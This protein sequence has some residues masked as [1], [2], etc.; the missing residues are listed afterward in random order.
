M[1]G[2]NSVFRG[3]LARGLLATF[4]IGIGHS[5]FLTEGVL[6]QSVLGSSKKDWRFDN[7][8]GA[9]VWIVSNKAV[10]SP[11]LRRDI[12]ILI[13]PKYFKREILTK[14]FADLSRKLSDT[15]GV[16]I[17]AYSDEESLHYS[18]VL[19]KL[20]NLEIDWN[21]LTASDRKS[22]GLHINPPVRKDR[23]FRAHYFVDPSREFFYYTPL[24]K[25]AKS[26]D[27]EW[28]VLREDKDRAESRP[29]EKI[30][31]KIAKI[32]PGEWNPD[33]RDV[34]G[35]TQLLYELRN[36]YFDSARMLIMLGAGANECSPG[37]VCPLMLA[38]RGAPVE[39]ISL[40]ID[41]GAKIDAEDGR[42][43]TA[44]MYAAE[45]GNKEAIE[46]L[47]RHG[48]KVNAKDHLSQT[49]L[50]K[51]S[52][53]RGKTEVAELLL[54]AGAEIDATDDEGYTAL[55]RA[56]MDSNLERVK[57]LL[58]W[59]AKTVI[60]D[61]R[62]YTALDLAGL[63]QSSGVRE[64]KEIIKLLDEAIAKQRASGSGSKR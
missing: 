37:G 9:P 64:A 57:L 43:N 35:W 19:N 1:F 40:L 17:E 50:M 27:V 38:A 63:E 46:I 13:E 8:S 16:T 34:M 54:N 45:G 55:M 12:Y 25:P 56:V 24:A 18:I 61:K 26:N 33:A 39:V 7:S 30:E 47:L 52:D 48:A 22:L 29:E 3:T 20:S 59:G 41:K 5:V 23:I 51:V 14:V 49:V 11:P 28:V 53:E 44:L 58:K 42:R 31:E 2:R 6:S 21:S 62:G 4:L 15:N 10:G 32:P 36:S 60:K